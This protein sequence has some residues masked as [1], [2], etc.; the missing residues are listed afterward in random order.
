MRPTC[1]EILELSQGTGSTATY[2][3]WLR[4]E[5]HD[6]GLGPNSPSPRDTHH[7]D[8]AQLRRQRV[9]QP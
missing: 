2:W 8:R 1:C 3:P 7:A 9:H 5:P 4:M 6:I